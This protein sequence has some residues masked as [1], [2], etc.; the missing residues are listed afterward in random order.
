MVRLEYYK[1]DEATGL[2]EK[3]N[4]IYSFGNLFKG[5]QKQ[6]PIS[7]KNVGD[8]DAI[9]PVITMKQYVSEDGKSYPE[10]YK[11]KRLGYSKDTI[12]EVE[13]RLPDIKAGGWLEG[14]DVFTEDFSLYP[15]VAGTPLGNDW[16]VWQ[17]TGLSF[18]VYNGWLQHNPDT[19]DG[20]A[21][22]TVLPNA[23]NFIYSMKITVR[24]GTYA[25]VLL[26]NEGDSDTGYIVLV[27]GMP[28][29]LGDGVAT[30]EGVIQIYDGKFT[31]GIDSWNLLYTSPNIGIRG[32][33]DYFKVK[34]TDNRF[35][36]WYNN[37]ESET[38]LC[39]FID[40]EDLHTNPTK[41]IILSHAGFGSVLLYFDDI[42]MEVPNENGI[43]WIENNVP[44]TT[45]TFGVQYSILNVEY[46]GV[47]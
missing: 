4:N 5:S 9:S 25:G 19:M 47:E 30:N 40:E 6:I 37:E 18:E 38:P 43:I 31:E 46:G 17:G 12:T 3:I 21:M 34:M 29:K 33:H 24:D 36:F 15:T 27:Q 20:R 45:A 7:I 8:T 35:D 10:A 1:V 2:K 23:K 22:W 39:S 26:R 14:K 42:Y 16:V 32:T 41:P 44:S 13:L 28:D 11:W